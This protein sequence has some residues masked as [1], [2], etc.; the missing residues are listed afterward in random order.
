M[1]LTAPEWDE[2]FPDVCQILAPSQSETD[3]G[4]TRETFPVLPGLESLG[5]QLIFKAGEV[6]TRGGV[7]VGQSTHLCNLRQRVAAIEEGAGLR[8][9]IRG[10]KF[11]VLSAGSDSQ[12]VKTQLLLSLVK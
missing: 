7:Q 4:E 5:A 6:V 1:D 12:G 2:F 11:F 3:M 8:A 10:Q 9:V